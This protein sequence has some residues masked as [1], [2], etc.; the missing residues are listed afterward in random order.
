MVSTRRRFVV[1]EPTTGKLVAT[2]PMT[3]SMPSDIAGVYYA[4]ASHDG[5]YGMV[6]DV[7]D[8]K[9]TAEA[10]VTASTDT[11]GVIIS[12]TYAMKVPTLMTIAGRVFAIVRTE[13]LNTAAANTGDA[14]RVN[15]YVQRNGTLLGSTNGPEHVPNSTTAVAYEDILIVDVPSTDFSA[16]DDFEVK[17]EVE[18]TSVDA[19]N[20]G[21]QVTLKCDPA[22]AGNE[23]IFYLQVT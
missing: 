22:T 14:F 17:V 18:V 6:P 5:K 1:F 3:S 19:T 4:V 13:A 8:I 12:R 16:G 11:T 21:I 15:L 2:D 9:K 7:G 20:P 23:L 10:S